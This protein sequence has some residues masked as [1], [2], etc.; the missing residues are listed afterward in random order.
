MELKSHTVCSSRDPPS[1]VRLET[2]V[3]VILP[4]IIDSCCEAVDSPLR[5]DGT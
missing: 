4:I 1:N 2:P 3:T 5:G